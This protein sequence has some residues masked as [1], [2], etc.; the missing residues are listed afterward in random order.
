[1]EVEKEK[2]GV[3]PHTNKHRLDASNTCLAHGSEESV[4]L[5][6][7]FKMSDSQQLCNHRLRCSQLAAYTLPIDLYLL[8]ILLKIHEGLARG[9]KV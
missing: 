5:V 1:M 6:S 4:A 2:E 7:T 3:E 8:V 9:D